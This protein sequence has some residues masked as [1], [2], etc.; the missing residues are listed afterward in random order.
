MTDN[1]LRTFGRARRQLPTFALALAL[2]H[3]VAEPVHAENPPAVA[4]T[5]VEAPESVTASA[6]F[7]LRVRVANTGTVPVRDCVVELGQVLTEH[8][9]ITL[10]YRF[11]SPPRRASLDGVDTLQLLPAGRVLAPGE[12]YERHVWLYASS[13]SQRGALHLYVITSAG[14]HLTWS[15]QPRPIIVTHP[16]W[17]VRRRELVTWT[18]LA[19]Y[20]LGVAWS[21]ARI[22]RWA[23][24]WRR[25]PCSS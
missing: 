19:V 22:V 11:W 21:V 24:A 3:S 10:G 14:G 6:G 7:S 2:L 18:L 15:A 4:V 25:R 8:P 16:S 9:C 20:V 5:I 17:A 23:L 13:R 12:S 1:P